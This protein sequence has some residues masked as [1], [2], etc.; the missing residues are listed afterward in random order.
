MVEKRDQSPLLTL[1]L[2]IA[3]SSRAQENLEQ[4]VNKM[5]IKQLREQQK[6]ERFNLTQEHIDFL[7]GAPIVWDPSENGA[8]IIDPQTLHASGISGVATALAVFL[9]F[10]KIAA[11]KYVIPNTVRHHYQQPV[12]RADVEGNSIEIPQNEPI[13]FELTEQHIK[14]LHAANAAALVYFGAAGINSRKPYGNMTYFEIDM[15]HI[16]GRPVYRDQ[17]GSPSFTEEEIEFFRKLHHEMLF[18]MPAFLAHAEIQPGTFERQPSAYA[19][20]QQQD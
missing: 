10:G 17:N 15:A 1:A 20:W 16:L 9:K 12:I 5:R 6:S 7:R 4:A 18:A 14:L 13:E 8:P 19:S 3:I 11:G 2:L